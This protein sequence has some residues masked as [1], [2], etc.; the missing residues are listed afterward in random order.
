MSSSKWSTPPHTPQFLGSIIK[1]AATRNPWLPTCCWR[2][3]GSCWTAH[4]L[5][6]LRSTQYRT[7]RSRNSGTNNII[8]R[9]SV[10]PCGPSA[11]CMGGPRSHY[12]KLA[13]PP[14]IH[15]SRLCRVKLAQLTWGQ[16]RGCR[17]HHSSSM[18]GRAGRRKMDGETL[19][20]TVT[21]VGIQILDGPHAVDKGRGNAAVYLGRYLP[22]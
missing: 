7:T 5:L 8:C 11:G 16:I 2:V 18:S 19:S 21:T 6:S 3:L 10:G 20:T 12:I 17:L 15:L 9:Y 4:L 22:R 13:P 1:G 14:F